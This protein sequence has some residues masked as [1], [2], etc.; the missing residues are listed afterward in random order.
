MYLKTCGHKLPEAPLV[1]AAVV[2]VARLL[3][4]PLAR[5]E[6]NKGNEGGIQTLH[7]SVV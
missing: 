5:G 7:A 3:L 1:V 6:S 4:R 2:S